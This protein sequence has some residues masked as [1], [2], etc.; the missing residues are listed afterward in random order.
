MGLHAEMT[1][2]E[3]DTI[4]SMGASLYAYDILLQGAEDLCRRALAQHPDL[5]DTSGSFIAE[6]NDERGRINHG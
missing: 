1:E 6:L 5:A 4:L 2:D 3:A